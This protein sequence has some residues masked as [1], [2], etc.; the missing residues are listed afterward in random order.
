MIYK[1]WSYQNFIANRVS[2]P[3]SVGV[4]ADMGLGKTV[5]TLTGFLIIRKEHNKCLIVAPKKVAESVWEDEIN[6][7]DHLEHLKI[8]KILGSPKD[9]LKALQ[10]KADLYIINRENLVWLVNLYGSNWPFDLIII[11]ELS[12]FKN[13]TSKRFKA[14]KLILRYTKKI[15]G[16]TG[17]PA[18]NG[19]LDL[20][21]QVYLLDKGKRLGETISQFREKYFETDKRNAHTIFSY[22]LKKGDTLLGEDFFEKEIYDRIGDIC[23]SMK[24]KDYIDLPD[25]IDNNQYIHFDKEL[26]KRYDDFERDQVLKILDTELTAINAAALTQKLLQFA[27]G[28]VY[29]ENKKS[30]SVHIEKLEKLDELVEELNGKPVLV[31]YGFVADKEEILHKFKYAKTLDSNK[32]IKDWNEGKIKMLVAHPASAGHGLNLQ[33]GGSHIIW[34]S[35]PW[36]LELYLQGCKRLHRPG[37]KVPVINTRIIAKNTI[38]EDVIKALSDKTKLQ[39]AVISAVKARIK[40]Y[41]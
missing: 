15:I 10:N 29:D 28:F 39:D 13:S 5:S 22:K 26:Q 21:S 3:N 20:W 19:L 41:F 2:D 31:F 24:S 6:K 12:S 37:I 8:S 7:W 34:Y 35:S 40:K 16:L 36:S 18:P 32:E 9:R 30:H 11:D 1:P 14:F 27:N 17:T 33:F 25:L 23:F 4:F 38:D